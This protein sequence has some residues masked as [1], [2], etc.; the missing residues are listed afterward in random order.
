LQ[1]QASITDEEVPVAASETLFAEL[2]AAGKTTELYTYPNDNHNISANFN[3][4]MARSIAW[5]DQYVKGAT[6]AAN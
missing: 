2:K 6:A 3:I 5:F 1:L 4:A